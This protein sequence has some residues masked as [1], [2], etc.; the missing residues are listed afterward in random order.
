M[1]LEELSAS[2]LRLLRPQVGEV[3]QEKIDALLSRPEAK[4]VEP[5]RPSM[6]RP[7]REMMAVLEMRKR[8]GEVE[9][10]WYECVKLKVGA[11]KCWYTCDYFVRRTDGE[12][13]FI[14]VKGPRITD[15]ARVKYM[16][17]AREHSWA[18]W[19]LMKY[20][21]GRWFTVHEQAPERTAA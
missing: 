5:K 16:A 6:T 13:E 14:E 18:H 20:E 4:V 11:H 2:E 21:G 12:F 10:Y 8:M 17:A 7:E 3:M 15:D 9:S 19:R 1:R